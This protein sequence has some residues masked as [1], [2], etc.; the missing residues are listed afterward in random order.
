MDIW[1]QP[2]GKKEAVIES[3]EL[4]G[5]KPMENKRSRLKLQVVGTLDEGM[6]LQIKDIGLGELLPGSNQEWEYEIG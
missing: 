3:L 2:L 5:W 6:K 1:V 4:S